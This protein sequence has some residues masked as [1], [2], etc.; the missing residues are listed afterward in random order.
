MVTFANNMRQKRT[1]QGL[2]LTLKN[3]KLR[4]FSTFDFRNLYCFG[5]RNDRTSSV[6]LS[7][8]IPRSAVVAEYLRTNHQLNVVARRIGNPHERYWV[9]FSEDFRR[10]HPIMCAKICLLAALTL[11]HKINFNN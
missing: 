11:N 8:H 1:L 7:P 4:H 3:R 2:F 10:H 9:A 5:V 6:Y